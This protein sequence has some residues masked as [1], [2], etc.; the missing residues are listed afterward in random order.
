MKWIKKRKKSDGGEK[1]EEKMGKWKII[2]TEND[3]NDSK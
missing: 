2:P 1:E 3:D